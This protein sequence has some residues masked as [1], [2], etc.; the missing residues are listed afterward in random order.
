MAEVFLKDI[1]LISAGVFNKQISNFIFRNTAQEVIGGTTYLVTQPKNIEDASLLG[2]EVGLTKRFSSLPGILSGF[3]IEANYTRISS[4][5]EVPR[6]DAAGKVLSLDETSLP[7]QSKNLFN[8]SF[9]YERNG[10]M[11]RLAGNFR[12]NAVESINQNLGPDYYIY[13][14]DN[15]TVD[16]S[17]AYSFSDRIKGFVEVRNLTNEPYA[18]YL[19]NNSNR[20][21]NREWHSVSGQAGIR[22]ILF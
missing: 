22:L 12:G 18:L 20:A 16:F 15:F 6:L 10:L 21:T 7:S 4:T 19:G 8:T 5:L 14:D 3:G 13:V 1:G 17:G 11:L 2:F 9:F